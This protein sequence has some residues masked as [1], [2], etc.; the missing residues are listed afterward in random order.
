MITISLEEGDNLVPLLN[1]WLDKHSSGKNRFEK[2]EGAKT[3]KWHIWQFDL[4]VGAF[5]YLD[6]EEFLTF[7][8]TLDW[9][10]ETQLFV[11]DEHEIQFQEMKRG[12]L[13]QYR[14]DK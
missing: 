9:E 11:K 3:P 13:Y 6:I 14:G 1:E 2:M 4:F 5:N 10:E 7:F 8:W 12:T